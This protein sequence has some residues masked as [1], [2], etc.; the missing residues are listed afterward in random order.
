[1]TRNPSRQVPRKSG[2]APLWDAH[3]GS[4]SC[5]ARAHPLVPPDPS[6]FLRFGA[7]LS[8]GVLFTRCRGVRQALFVPGSAGIIGTKGLR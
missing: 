2:G 3:S 6:C 1:M 7:A 4:A 5:A 8:G